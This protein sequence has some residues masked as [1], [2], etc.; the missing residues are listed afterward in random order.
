MKAI[1]VNAVTSID[2]DDKTLQV[3]K[4]RA[5]ERGESFEESL[6]RV[7]MDVAYENDIGICLETKRLRELALI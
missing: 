1:A 4:R 5:W 6:R 2:L 3:L 7:L